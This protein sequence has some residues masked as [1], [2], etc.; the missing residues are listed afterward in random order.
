MKF[1]QAERDEIKRALIEEAGR[2][3]AIVAAAVFGSAARG[4][5]DAWSDI[6]LG[7]AVA[8]DAD[9]IDICERWTALMKHRYAVCDTLD[10]LSHGA[11]YRVF[12]LDNTLQI[13]LSFWPEE[14]FVLF[15]EEPELLFGA[16]RREKIPPPDVNQLIGRGWLYMLHARSYI[17][18]SRTW[19][20]HLMLESWRD[21]IFML[22]CYRL[23]IAYDKGLGIDSLPP[24]ILQSIAECMP[25]SPNRAEHCLCFIGLSEFYMEEVKV[26]DIDRAKKL[27]IPVRQMQTEIRELLRTLEDDEEKEDD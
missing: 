25:V 13:D 5:E 7:F 22:L 1:S 19:Q 12:W 2:D 17:S 23:H 15:G 16:A 26:I 18:R 27:I 4:E 20:A 11:L 10:V 3:E 21:Q 6:D 24:K 8:K 9:I 14:A